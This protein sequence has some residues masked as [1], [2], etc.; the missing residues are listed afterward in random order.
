MRVV[1]S[2]DPSAQRKFQVVF[3]NGSTIDVKQQDIEGM[4]DDYVFQSFQTIALQP[5]GVFAPTM[6]DQAVKRGLT[7]YI[8]AGL[9][10]MKQLRDR[11]VYEPIFKKD[12]PPDANIIPLMLILHEKILAHTGELERIKGRC[13]GR[14]DKEI[15]YLDYTNG[16][17]PTIH[18]VTLKIAL[19]LILTYHFELFYVD[20]VGGYLNTDLPNPA[21]AKLPKGFT[22]NGS[23]YAKILK[24]LYGL[25]DSGRHF[26]N[27]IMAVIKMFG[28]FEKNRVDACFYVYKVE[29]KPAAIMVRATDNLLIGCR[30]S[31]LVNELRTFLE[32]NDLPTTMEN[33]NSVLG[34]ALKYTQREKLIIYNV[35]YIE[36]LSAKYGINDKCKKVYI[37]S[38]GYEYIWDIAYSRQVVERGKVKGDRCSLSFDSCRIGKICKGLQT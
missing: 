1:T 21:Y 36:S 22:E 23:E 10:E 17:A 19:V 13:V 33:K 26:S 31:S 2:V 9:A 16:F 11:K 3:E 29:N 25:H 32:K 24:S 7:E 4:D 12:I 20:V 37:Y 30:D 8:Q 28:C 34:M 6:F 35:K 18:P 38:Y 5:L 15:K 27:H 14:G